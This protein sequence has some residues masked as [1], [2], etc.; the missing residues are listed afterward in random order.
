MAAV[1]SPERDAWRLAVALR[2][3]A[4]LRLD[5]SRLAKQRLVLQSPG[6]AASACLGRLVGHRGE[7]I[8]AV[9]ELAHSAGSC[10][11]L[12]GFQPNHCIELEHHAAGTTCPADSDE[13]VFPA[14]PIDSQTVA[15]A[16]F[17]CSCNCGGMVCAS[18]LARANDAGDARRDALWRELAA[19]LLLRR[20]A[21]ARQ[22]R[23]AARHLGWACDAD[24]AQSW[25]NPGDDR[26]RDSAKLDQDQIQAAATSR[27]CS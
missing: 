2:A 10:R 11:S 13:T 25:W 5:R 19:N 21:G 17:F 22:P 9:G 20:D 24:R 14:G 23:G 1:A 8:P 3:R 12:S 15:T 26:R 27:R 4:R 6:L 7:E 16:A 18:R